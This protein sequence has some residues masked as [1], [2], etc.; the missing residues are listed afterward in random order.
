MFVNTEGLTKQTRLI[1]VVAA[2]LVI[3]AGGGVLYSITGSTTSVNTTLGTGTT[4]TSGPTVTQS[5]TVD[6]SKYLG[7]IP[8]GYSV[9][10]RSPNS[11]TFPCPSGMNSQQ[12][13]QFQATCG[14][15]VCDPNETCGSCPLDCGATGALVCDPYTGRPGTPAGVCQVVI[16]EIANGQ[17][18]LTTTQT[19]GSGSVTVTTTQHLNSTSTTSK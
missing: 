4:I 10:P 3:A 12:C 17:I 5:G 15:G 8:Q 13:Q 19:I 14:N 1:I 11:P 7:Y 18:T 2:V 6:T 16:Q 9:A